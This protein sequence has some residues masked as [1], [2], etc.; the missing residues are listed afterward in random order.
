MNISLLNV[1]LCFIELFLF[2]WNILNNMFLGSISN[3]YLKAILRNFHE[4]LLL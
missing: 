2:L 3:N 4:K 1:G